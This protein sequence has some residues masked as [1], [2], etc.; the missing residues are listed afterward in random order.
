MTD[1]LMVVMSHPTAVTVTVS[2]GLAW[3]LGL[4]AVGGASTLV[5]GLYWTAQ[6]VRRAMRGVA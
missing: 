3:L 2:R 1:T 5:L 6:D 4:F